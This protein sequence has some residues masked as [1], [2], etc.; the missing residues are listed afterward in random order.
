[1]SIFY[2]NTNISQKYFASI[3]LSIRRKNKYID[4]VI[5]L[6]ILIAI[7]QI[8]FDD[9]MSVTSGTDRY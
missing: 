2:E 3:G 8:I 1:M 6:G 5:L 4:D 9:L 7:E